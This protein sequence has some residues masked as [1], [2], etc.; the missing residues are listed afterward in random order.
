MSYSYTEKK[1]IRKNFGRFPKVMD[2]PTLTETQLNSYAMFLQANVDPDKRENMG[3]EEVFQSLFPIT[4]VSG[5]AALEYVSYELGKNSFDVQ[6]CL[7]QGLSYSAPLRIKVRLVIYDKESNFEEVKDVKEGEVFMGEVPLMTSTGSFIINGTERVVV[8]Q[9]HRSPGVFFDHDKGK[10]HSSGKVLYSARIIPYRGSWLDFEFDPKDSL[11]CRIDRKRKIPAT[12]LL[13]ALEMTTEEILQSFFETETYTLDKSRIKTELRPERLRGEVLNEEIKIKNKV[14]VEAGKR[15]TA[16]HVKLLR[17]SGEKEIS[18]SNEYLLGKFTSK[19]I[20]DE[21]TG[22]VTLA[23]NSEI[24]EDVL[25]LLSEKNITTIDTLYINELEKGPYI[26]NTLRID[27]TS[28]R[29]EALVEIYRMMRPGE[30]P[31]KDSAETLFRNLF[32]NP[33]RYD[34]SE[35]GRMKFN[36]RLKIEDERENPNVL[37]LQDIISVMKGIL[38]IRDGN[39]FVDDIDHLGN[40]RVRSVGEMTAN[41][42]RVGLIRVERAVRERLSMA[43]ADELGPQDLINAKPVTAAIKEFFGSSQ[44]SQFMDQNN[45]LSEITHKRRVS[46]LGPGGLTRERALSLVSPPGPNA[47]TLLL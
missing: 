15:V 18:F 10:T 28:N 24:D 12:I 29:L 39:D 8:S 23:C 32:F 20:F 38:D 33:E 3:L 19:D 22:E 26:A 37:D 6:E 17:D 25:S 21:E 4:S 45:P 5:N 44:L 2:L 42:F 1:R 34:L 16:R 31:T 30:P 35:V 13:K 27:P 43:E 41:Q 9:L 47:E 36:R 46:A 40:R 7:I 11:F 14:I